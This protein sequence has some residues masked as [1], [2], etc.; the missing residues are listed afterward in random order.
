MK[1]LLKKFQNFSKSKFFPIF[2]YLWLG[3]FSTL[4]FLPYKLSHFAWIAPFALF[5]IEKRYRGAWK[6]QFLHAHIAGLTT[7]IFSYFWITHLLVVFGG[8]PFFVAFPL[9]LFYGLVTNL[10]FPVFV[11]LFG[12]LRRKAGKQVAL[13]A[14]ACIVFSEFFTF[15][16]FPYYFGNLISG[17]SFLAQ[18]AEY[19]GVYGLSA[20][21][22]IVSYSLF[23]SF[24]I[25]IRYIE[26][27]KIWVIIRKT[28]TLPVSLLL[29]FFVTGGLLY[30]KWQNHEPAF[31][32]QVMMIQPNAPLEFRDGRFRETIE[33]LMQKIEDLAAKGAQDG[34]PDIIVLPESGVPFFSTHNTDATN[35][36][37]RSYYERFE[38]L[39]Y[40]LSVKYKASV[41]FNEVDATFQDKL[42]RKENQRFYNSS[43]V[44][45]PNGVRG[46]S[47][48]KV[49]LLAFGEYFP[50][51]ETFPI[52]YDII[53]QVGRFLPGQEQ[54]L[55][56]YYNPREELPNWNKS[57]LRW[58]DSSFMNVQGFR[59]YYKEREIPLEEKGK[60]L[61]LICY[62][63]IIPEFVRKFHRSGNPDFIINITNDK[64]YGRSMETFQHLELARMRSIEYRRWM[65]RSTNS[66]T[67][68]FVNHLGEVINDAYTGQETS[69]VY[70]SQIQVIRSEPTFYVKY[71]NLLSWIFMISVFLWGLWKSKLSA[72]LKR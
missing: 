40:L 12:Y 35:L 60:F 67:S 14:G 49:Y 23:R 41:Y 37:S 27:P 48:H 34:K 58:M 72:I 11:L 2:C 17:N 43:V 7:T 63:V 30:Y 54:N 32:Q 8:F 57:H 3:G 69:E 64:W 44:F 70:G 31:T 62:E 55:L 47:Y 36:F 18:N 25:G 42:P 71:G 52:I 65:V 10:R 29:L 51:G 19:T 20:I 45:D 22:F 50:L 26:K 46:D 68:V 39:M 5:W 1:T 38:A 56:K 53:P 33:N 66:G 24:G 9:F 21:V 6:K 4:A 15:Q 59:D 28:M 16:L 61:P 13:L